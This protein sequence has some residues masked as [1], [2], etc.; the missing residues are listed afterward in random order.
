MLT[1][2]V[3]F[4]WIAVRMREVDVAVVATDVTRTVTGVPPQ[5]FKRRRATSQMSTS[6]I[7]TTLEGWWTRKRHSGEACSMI[8][9][10]SNVCAISRNIVQL[11]KYSLVREMHYNT[12]IF[13]SKFQIL[14][15]PFPW[16]GIWQDQDWE[17]DEENNGGGC[18]EK[19][20]LHG[21]TPQHT[22]ETQGQ[23][24][25][26]SHPLPHP[27]RKQE[28]PGNWHHRHQEIDNRLPW[29]T[30]WIK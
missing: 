14:E 15:S 11:M 27:H 28:Q 10:G 26:D 3:I 21:H 17:A 2:F 12:G 13:H 4:R 9:N 24:V 7:W 29:V 19:H 30:S 23:T 22:P 8:L 16:E 1:F 25:W 5:P 18:D 6:H 20:V